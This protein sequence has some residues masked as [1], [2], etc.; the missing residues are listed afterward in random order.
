MVSI[1]A[2]LVSTFL[3][4]KSKEEYSPYHLHLPPRIHITLDEEETRNKRILIIGDVHGCLQELKQLL[5][6]AGAY[7]PNTCIVFTGDLINKGPDNVQVVRFVRQLGAYCVRGNHD[8]YSLLQYERGFY[9][10]RNPYFDWMEQL[11]EDDLQ[12]LYNLPYTISIP[13]I[14]GLIVHA[15]L[16]PNVKLHQQRLADLLEL[17]NVNQDETNS[18]HYVGSSKI[19]RGQPWAQ[20]WPGPLHI[21]FGHDARRGLQLYP[22]A[23]GLDTGCC[24]GGSITAVVVNP[25]LTRQFY[26]IKAKQV[27]RQPKAPLPS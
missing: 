7:Q 6:L 8:E 3:S 1:V 9:T 12:F 13:S 11:S 17:R 26:N 22:F 25:D 21:Y 4:E 18:N 20:T 5:T 16:V 10:N 15:G 24:Y 27:Y 14:N 19:D 2:V 23:T